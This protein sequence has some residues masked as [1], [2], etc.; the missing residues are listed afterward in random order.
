MWLIRMLSR[1][2]ILYVAAFAIVWFART[3]LIY[4]FSDVYKTPAQAGV[5]RLSEYRLTTHDGKSLIVWARPAKGHKATIV[6]FHGNAGNLANRA[7][8]FDRLIDRGYGVVALAY[9]GSSGST[10][11]PSEDVITKD[12]ILL[13]GSLTKILGQKPKGKIIYY[14][15]SLGTGVATKLATTH[16]PDALILEAPYTSIVTLAAKQMPIFP[17]RAVLDQR[18]ETEDYI[19]RVNIPI[20]VLHG[21]K[22]QVIPYTHG[23]VIFSLSPAKN[24]VMETLKGGDHAAAFSTAGQ[25]AIYR[26]IAGL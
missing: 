7:Q 19:K 1:L 4:P 9:R 5:P 26:F 20:L 14:G 6:Y 21:T 3:W 12:A 8:R 24:K 18:W 25:T 23:Q 17:I 11:R 16:P 10:G 22:D 2:A 15:E 13:K